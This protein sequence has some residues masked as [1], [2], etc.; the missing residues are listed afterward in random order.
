MAAVAAALDDAP[1]VVMGHDWGAPIVWNAAVL[2]PDR[3]AAVAGL[4]VPYSPPLPI[5]LVDLFDQLYA[6]R[7]FYMR[8]FQQPGV[9]E[10]AFAARSAGGPQAGAT[11]R[12]PAMRRSTACCPT[13]RRDAAL[14]PL[15]PE[16]PDGPLSFLSDDD[17][18]LITATFER[19]GLTGAFNRYRAVPYDVAASADLLDAVVDQPSCFIAGA[20]DPVRAM[21]P[22][23]DTYADPGVGLRRL[24]RRHHHRGRRPLGPAGGADRGQRRPRRL[25]R[26][27]LTGSASS[28]PTGVEPPPGAR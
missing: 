12:C 17:L 8:Y 16:P 28:T 20:L 10:A 9:A 1:V 4:S 3:V 25:P 24:P 5:S 2:H 15:L 27:D 23:A 13:R 14:L 6:D 19:T 22:G 21:I 7:F 11:S 26:L 18:D